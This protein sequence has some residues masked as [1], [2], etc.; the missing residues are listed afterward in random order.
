MLVGLRRGWLS[1]AMK[2]EPPGLHETTPNSDGRTSFHHE[3]LDVYQVALE[4]VHW[5]IELPGSQDLSER[6]CREID[7]NATS[8]VLNVAEGNGRYSELDQRRFLEITASSAAKTTAYLDLY[9]Q[10]TSITQVDIRPGKELLSRI[11]AMITSF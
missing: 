2:E 5:L 6:L 4:F 1:A 9:R 7:K 8:V 10:K 11:I 3:T